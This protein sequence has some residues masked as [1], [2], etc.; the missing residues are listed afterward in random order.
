[1][2][3][4]VNYT[5]VGIFVLLFGIGM[6]AFSFWLA[7]Y[8]LQQKYDL[9][10]VYMTE[11]VSG[12]SKDSVVKLRGVDVGRVKEIRIDP[13]DIERV[14]ILLEIK[15]GTP[16]KEDMVA[17]TMM[18][19]VTGLL[20][21][22][23]DG[24]TNSAPTLKPDKT[25]IPVIKSSSSWFDKTRKNIS[26]LAD[27]LAVVVSQTEKLLSNENI[28]TFGKILKHTEEVTV[29]S[30]GLVAEANET[31]IAYRQAVEHFNRD[32]ER[33]TEAFVKISDQTLP[34]VKKL[35]ETSQNFN[36]LTLKVEKSLDRGDYNF[37]KILEPMLVNIEIL[38]EQMGVVLRELEGS[39]SDVLFKSRKVRY[40][41]GEH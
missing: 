3:S 24:G 39:P 36:R 17:H 5:V 1:M 19:G 18:L 33:V 6:V 37:Q 12:L 23:I 4:R 38:T 31:I 32:L 29:K 27:R 15:E 14:E 22:E 40:G 41:P 13:H 7:K 35:K 10:K 16:I 30:A 11:S 9:Y 21:I 34:A 2:Y 28:E 25:D 26:T 8:G 20:A